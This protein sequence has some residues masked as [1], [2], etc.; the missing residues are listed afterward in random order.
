MNTL[1][2]HKLSTGDTIGVIAPSDPISPEQELKLKT[3]CL[4]LE[5]MGFNVQLGSYLK[6]KK[7]GY[8]D[9]PK[10][11]ANDINGMFADP[12][13]KGI[14]CAQGGQTANT[15]LS[16]ID[17]SII[18]KNPKIFLGLSDI[19]VLLN[20]IYH[21][22]KLITFHG[23]DILWGFGNNLT[24]YE[25]KEFTR[26]LMQ[27]TAGS[28]PTNQMRKTIRSGQSIGRLIGGNLGCMLKLA[29]TPY[30]PDFS[31]VI[32]FI[33]EYQ[34]T[35]KSCCSA[36]YHLGQLGVFDQIE[37]IVLGYIDSMEK[38]AS[39]KPHMEDVLMQVTEAYHFPILKMND[40]GHNCPN[41]V[42]PVGGEV[43]LDA[44]RQILEIT[45]P[46]VR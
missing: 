44:D 10:E 9:A 3:G 40:F 37:G 6:S 32:L 42:L 34:I 41:T 18:K 4:S 11:K 38:T 29:G 26:I 7:C 22:T 28:Y 46:C 8:A 15:T 30:W 14:I 23:N 33:E 25:E 20:A 17:W 24:P 27:G 1:L 12:S 16:F 43:Y 5:K 31:G 2:P 19:S 35:A 39:P 13:I 36:F 21:K 45:Q